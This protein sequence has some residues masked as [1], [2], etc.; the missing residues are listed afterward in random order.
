VRSLA[1]AAGLLALG[2][3]LYAGAR[4]T[5][6]FAIRTIDV[7]GV[8]PAR[9]AEVRRAL[10]PLEGTSLLALT[11]DEIDR[12]LAALPDVANATYDRSFPNTLRLV[13]TPE[14]GIAVLRRGAGAW[15]VSAD[16]RVISSIVRG[17]NRAIP[18]IW[19]AR[20]TDVHVGD[21]L[22]PDEG[23]RSVSA[24]VLAARQR[25]PFAIAAGRV[26]RRGLAFVLR[27]GLEL[28]LGDGGELALKLAIARHTIPYL[29]GGGAGEYLDLSV[30]ERP[31][32]GPLKSQVGG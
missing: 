10:A 25:F 6:V 16:A 2:A 26:D 29:L 30:P 3:S 21:T 11:G 13:V 24:L 7:R 19:V 27:T 22:A 5:S 20:S 4:Y 15:L 23:G 8:G 14:R 28:R 12:R 31:V 1:T 17:T 32:A 9:G 18:R